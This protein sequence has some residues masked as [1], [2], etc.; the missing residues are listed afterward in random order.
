ML[1]GG[2]IYASC[3][4]PKQAAAGRFTVGACCSGE[5]VPAWPASPWQARLCSV[6]L[7]PCLPNIGWHS[8]LCDRAVRGVAAQQ[9]GPYTCV[10]PLQVSA[11]VAKQLA[12]TEDSAPWS[13]KWA[14]NETAAAL[15]G[16]GTS[17]HVLPCAAQRLLPLQKCP[18]LQLSSACFVACELCHQGDVKIICADSSSEREGRLSPQRKGNS[19]RRVGCRCRRQNGNPGEY[20]YVVKVLSRGTPA[21][22][23]AA[24]HEAHVLSGPLRGA[25]HVARLSEMWQTEE[26][27]Y[28]IL[29]CVA[30]TC[31]E[32]CS[33]AGV[34]RERGACAK[35]M[36]SG[37]A[38]AVALA[39]GTAQQKTCHERRG[40]Q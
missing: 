38:K 25:P 29:R 7:L 24:A 14:L 16:A 6:G 10:R 28:V 35:P 40:C 37:A 2:C 17:G 8:V 26:L 5:Q 1:V 22:R 30:D 36:H 21:E 13:A 19:H 3:D 18:R 15:A 20:P 27:A 23:A 11:A 9:L 4:T 39:H 12:A 32:L 34:G 33:W 31:K